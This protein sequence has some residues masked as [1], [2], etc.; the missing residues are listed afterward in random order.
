MERPDPGAPDSSDAVAAPSALSPKVAQ[1]ESPA[2]ARRSDLF[3]GRSGQ[4]FLVLLLLGLIVRFIPAYV[5][6]GSN[7]VGSWRWAIRLFGQGLNP[8]TTGKLNW[9][10]LWPTMLLYT[11]RMEAVYNLPDYLSVKIIPIIADVSI[12]LALYFWFLET[13]KD[14][15]RAFRLALWYI[16]N[17][18]AISNC[19]MHGQFDALPVLFTLLAVMAATRAKGDLS[20]AAALWLSLGIMAK[21]WPIIFVPLFFSRIRSPIGRLVFV[22]L[23]LAPTA[24]SLAILYRQAPEPI[25]KYVLTYRGNAAIYGFT[26]PRYFL[27]RKA[28]FA[29]ASFERMVLYAVWVATWVVL[30]RRG[31]LITGVCLL[32]LDF[33][34]FTSGLGAQ[35]FVWIVGPAVMGDFKRMRIYTVLMGLMLAFTYTFSPYD[36]EWFM[37]LARTRTHAFYLANVSDHKKLIDVLTGIPIWA[38]FVCWWVALWRDTLAGRRETDVDPALLAPVGGNESYTNI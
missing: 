23:A 37:F 24:I 25:V 18:I 4:Y 9:P 32:L 29:L 11:G 17:P 7:D 27:S 15:G 8:Y 10:P 3:S 2:R 33:F 28:G 16:L 22:L 19:A 6:Y 30:W 13:W 12:G 14:A 1:G 35:Y 26:L 38:L 5:F 34:V 21:T 36:G 20:I 31:S